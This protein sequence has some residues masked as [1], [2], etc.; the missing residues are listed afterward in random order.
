MAIPPALL[1]AAAAHPCFSG[2]FD[3]GNQIEVHHDPAAGPMR[4]VDFQ[5]E[6]CLSF[7]LACLATDLPAG[8]SPRQAAAFITQHV[9]TLRGYALSVGG[10][11]TVISDWLSAVYW[12]GAA[13]FALRSDRGRTAGK[14]SLDVLIKSVQRGLIKPAHPAMLD[15]KQ[16]VTQDVYLSVVPPPTVTSAAA[17]LASSHISTSPKPGYSNVTLAEFLPLS[18]AQPAVTAPVAPPP[19]AHPVRSRGP[20]RP[21]HPVRSRRGED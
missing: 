10:Y 2:V 1:T 13:L 4:V 17:L 5:C 16:Y 9:R 18:R 3:S 6:D 14:L 7:R 19:A 12:D 8:M 15:P 21:A 11:H 20:R